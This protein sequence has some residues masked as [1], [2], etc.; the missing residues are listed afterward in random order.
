MPVTNTKLNIFIEN[1]KYDNKSLEL[2]TLKED[3]FKNA[4]FSN[5]QKYLEKLQNAP[6]KYYIKTFTLDNGS[7]DGYYIFVMNFKIYWFWANYKENTKYTINRGFELTPISEEDLLN[8]IE[9]SILSRIN[10]PTAYEPYISAKERK[11]VYYRIYVK[12]YIIFYVVIDNVMEVRRIL[13]N[14]RDFKKHL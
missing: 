8:E 7:E 6:I 13:Y 3:F 2:V 5:E 14:K 11:N 9:N 10:F 4:N 12:N 1:L